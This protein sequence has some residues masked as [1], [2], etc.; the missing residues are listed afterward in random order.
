MAKPGWYTAYPAR[1]NDGTWMPKALDMKPTHWRLPKAPKN[2]RAT[3]MLPVP[4]TV[5]HQPP[6]AIEL[7]ALAG[8]HPNEIVRFTQAQLA[9][10]DKHIAQYVRRETIALVGPVCGLVGA[11]TMFG[12]MQLVQ[13]T[14]IDQ[15]NQ[16]ATNGAVIDRYN[17][18]LDDME[19]LANT[20]L[21]TLADQP[22][23]AELRTPEPRRRRPG[24][25]ITTTP[26]IAEET[27]TVTV[28]ASTQDPPLAIGGPEVPGPEPSDTPDTA[29][30]FLRLPDED[31]TQ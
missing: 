8:I 5:Q 13:R 26:F 28:V 1:Y 20:D 15:Y 4:Q 17:A 21:S 7:G 25:V 2:G 30:P 6:T 11:V 27:P 9:D 23:V 16:V 22:Q 19:E 29:L 18:Q 10:H 3:G 31:P 14:T 12:L 24:R